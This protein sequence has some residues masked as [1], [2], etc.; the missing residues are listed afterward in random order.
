MKKVY[1]R[2]MSAFAGRSYS[3]KDALRFEMSRTDEAACEPLI[4][5][6][7]GW[8]SGVANINQIGLI[9]RN[10]SI[11]REFR[12]DC[13]SFYGQYERKNSRYAK[14][15][16]NPSRLY[17]GRVNPCSNHGEAWA[18]MPNA[19][20]GFVVYGSVFELKEE[21]RNALLKVAHRHNLP[22]YDLTRKGEL[23]E[24]R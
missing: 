11:F 20:I 13:W 19:V 7:H 18:K 8:Y 6:N 24:R 5:T 16:Q 9:L 12:R 4:R 15:D 2:W 3:I 10:E 1:V 23:I 14:K 21:R 22:V 17:P